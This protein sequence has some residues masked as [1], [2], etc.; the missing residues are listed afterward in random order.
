M[1]EKKY[2]WLKLKEDFFRDKRI[3]KLRSIAGGDTYTLIYLKLQLLSLKN[4]GELFFE[5]VEDNFI[6]EIALEIDEDFENVK[7]TIMFLLKNGLIE[8]VS[9][10]VYIL[11]ETKKCIG[12]ESASTERVRKSRA[13][14]K[15]NLLQCNTDETKCNTEIE[16]ELELEKD[17]EIDSVCNNAHT[18]EDFCHLGSSY[19]SESCFRCMKKKKCPHPP[20]A[21]FQLKHSL[22]FEE[23]D[24]K[25]ENLYQDWVAH[26]QMNSLPIVSRELFDYDWLNDS[27]KDSEVD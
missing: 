20:S 5:G 2:Y 12:K 26:Q 11:I 6:E 10:D 7:V 22:T 1:A 24:E 4:D 9:E 16:I 18:H 21:E 23:Y 8:E 3:K 19:K 25:I 27:D 17:I 13:N 14:R 15:D